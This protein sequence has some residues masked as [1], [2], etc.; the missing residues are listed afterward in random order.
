MIAPA[1]QQQPA[2][3]SWEAFNMALWEES[4]GLQRLNV[5]AYNLTTVLVNGTS[6]Q[7]AL[8]DRELNNARLAHQRACS[9]RRGMQVR[10]FG[11]MTLEQVCRYAPVHLAGH[12][13]QRLAELRYGSIALGITVNNNK[14]L[15]V[16]GLD[17]LLKTTAKLQEVMTER[18]GVYKRRGFV[19][20]PGASV[21]VSSKV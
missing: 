1:V 14:A 19:A 7:I 21:R 4:V 11:T 18:T 6:D 13:N 16:A 9:K 3:D 2:G 17:R 5:A 10:G 15:I 12:F 20:P 8:A